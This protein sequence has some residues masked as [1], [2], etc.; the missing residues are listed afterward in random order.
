MDFHQSTSLWNDPAWSWNGHRRLWGPEITSKEQ[1]LVLKSRRRVCEKACAA[2]HIEE[3]KM[4]IHRGT[5]LLIVHDRLV[6]M[7]NKASS[8]WLRGCSDVL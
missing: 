7:M 6:D 5:R 3:M 1:F 2:E 8:L 4:R